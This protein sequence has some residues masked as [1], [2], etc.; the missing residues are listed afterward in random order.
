MDISIRS[1]LSTPAE[2]R[3]VAHTPSLPP[4]NHSADARNAG[5]RAGKHFPVLAD[6]I[7]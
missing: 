5:D 4:K 6:R 7:F 1:N 2:S 3:L